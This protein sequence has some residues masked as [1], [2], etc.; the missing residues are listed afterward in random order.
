[1]ERM[2]ISFNRTVFSHTKPRWSEAVAAITNKR[3]DFDIVNVISTV[4]QY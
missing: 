4:L 3:I 2:T 1:M